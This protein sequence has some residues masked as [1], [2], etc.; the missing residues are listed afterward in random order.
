[1]RAQ[2]PMQTPEEEHSVGVGEKKVPVLLFVV[3]I[4]EE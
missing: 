2:P 1:M 4:I 3:K